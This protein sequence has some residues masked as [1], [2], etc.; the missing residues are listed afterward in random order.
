[1]IEHLFANTVYVKVFPNRFELKHIES[2]KTASALS[3]QAFSTTRLL[4]GEFLPAEDALKKGIR[5]LHKGR[6]FAPKPRVVIQPMEKADNGLSSVEE[7]VLRELAAGAG[8]RESVI[9]VGH[10]LSDQ[11]VLAKAHG[12]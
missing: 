3:A 6:W 4:V 2:G 10:Q 5:E 7:R 11:E 9:W 8:A 1:M 12:I